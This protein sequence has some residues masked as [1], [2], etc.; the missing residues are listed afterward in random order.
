MTFMQSWQNGWRQSMQIRYGYHGP[1]APNQA[2]NRGGAFATPEIFKTL[3]SN[4]DICRNFQ[5]IKMKVYI[6]NIF[7]KSYLNFVYLAR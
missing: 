2:R 3:Q 5:R 4:F 1:S 6:L 7:E